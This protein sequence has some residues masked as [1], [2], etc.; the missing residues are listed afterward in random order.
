MENTS[1]HHAG[2]PLFLTTE[3]AANIT[4]SQSSPYT[5]SNH[6]S[7][8]D[9]SNKKID[10]NTLAEKLRPPKNLALLN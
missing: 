10:N 5:T 3:D 1:P 2:P 8:S 9:L 4:Q 7:P 6:S